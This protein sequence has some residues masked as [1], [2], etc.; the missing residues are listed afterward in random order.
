VYTANGGIS[1]MT[2]VVV[3]RERH[4][5]LLVAAG[6]AAVSAAVLG[7]STPSVAADPEVSW[8]G[9]GTTVFVAVIDLF[10]AGLSGWAAF[11]A[12]RARVVVVSVVAILL[13]VTV[14]LEVLDGAF[15]NH[16]FAGAQTIVLLFLIAAAANA[17]V[18]LLAA[19]ELILGRQRRSTSTSKPRA[20]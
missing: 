15:A 6:L 9:V 11:R 14:G 13:A 3:K 19:L 1:K 17:L 16:A 12:N 4:Y 10:L 7:A 2:G 18:V 5:L 8:T 20:A